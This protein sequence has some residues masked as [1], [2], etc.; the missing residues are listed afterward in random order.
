[1]PTQITAPAIHTTITR[2]A[3]VSLLVCLA[4]ASI[5]GGCAPAN[6]TQTR[7]GLTA[8][9]GFRTLSTHLEPAV[10]VLTTVAAAEQALRARGY[11]ID[12]SEVTGDEAVIV[13]RPP[14]GGSYDRAVIESRVTK[15]GTCLAVRIEPFGNEAA[16]Y[17][18][19]D[20]VL[21]R[22]GR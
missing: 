18:I 16:S 8:R 22:L 2:A 3:A 13:A 6:R 5:L 20:A 7:S 12:R 11:A 14:R 15:T 17:A 9:Y 4:A 1:M 10:S 21:L 19:M